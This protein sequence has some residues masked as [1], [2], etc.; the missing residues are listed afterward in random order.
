M[1]PYPSLP[2]TPKLTNIAEL[3]YFVDDLE[4]LPQ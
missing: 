4:D 3:D 1:L 2:Y